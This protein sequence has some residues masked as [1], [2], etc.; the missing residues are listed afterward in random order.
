MT[1]EWTTAWYYRLGHVIKKTFPEILDLDNRPINFGTLG[2][3]KPSLMSSHCSRYF[4]QI[5]ATRY[6][7]KSNY[8]CREHHKLYRS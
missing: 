2:R 1:H 4:T 6:R 3:H 5:P 7:S 8:L